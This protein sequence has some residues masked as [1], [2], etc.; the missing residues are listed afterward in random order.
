MLFVCFLNLA[1]IPEGINFKSEFM[2]I[3]NYLKSFCYKCRY[4]SGLSLMLWANF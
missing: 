2:Y 4:E 1:D 3:E